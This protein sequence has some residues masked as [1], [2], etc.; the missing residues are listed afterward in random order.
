MHGSLAGCVACGMTVLT[1]LVLTLVSSLQLYLLFL[2][3][4]L[5][6]SYYLSGLS[7]HSADFTVSNTSNQKILVTGGFL[8]I[9]YQKCVMFAEVC[10]QVMLVTLCEMPS[11]EVFYIKILP[12][13]CL[14][15]VVGLFVVVFFFGGG[16]FFLLEPPF[17][18]SSHVFC[19]DD[20]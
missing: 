20:I 10:F 17:F 2:L 7:S 19:L 9:F 4:S 3:L 6:L 14:F 13:F 1:L 11:S 18:V 16:D 15:V 12:F 8:K 5:C